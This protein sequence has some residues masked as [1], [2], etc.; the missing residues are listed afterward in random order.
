MLKA[1][2]LLKVVYLIVFLFGCNCLSLAW[3]GRCRLLYYGYRHRETRA[4]GPAIMIT[5]LF[6]LQFDA[7]VLDHGDLNH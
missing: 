7:T 4:N 1:L 5:V 3:M 2:F 6:T